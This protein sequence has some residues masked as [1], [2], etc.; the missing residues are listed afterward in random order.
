MFDCGFLSNIK[1]NISKKVSI[2]SSKKALKN[3][4]EIHY[5]LDHSVNSKTQEILA[6]ITDLSLA[7]AYYATIEPHYVGCECYQ[8]TLN[9]MLRDTL[10]NRDIAKLD[11]FLGSVIKLKK[12]VET[13][14][15]Y[16]FKEEWYTKYV[17][18]S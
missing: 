12:F 6:F 18:D 4:F 8:C 1:M 16:P 13:E 17:K 2:S 10:R 3:G 5:A 11:K 9:Y 15:F 14:S 7:E